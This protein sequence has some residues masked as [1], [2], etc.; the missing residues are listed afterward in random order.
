MNDNEYIKVNSITNNET[1]GVDGKMFL[2]FG[3]NSWEVMT[4]DT[5]VSVIP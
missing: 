1:F 4:Q 5:S 3:S 2:N